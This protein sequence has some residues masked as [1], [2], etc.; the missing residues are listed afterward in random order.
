M[1]VIPAVSVRDD[2]ASDA[3]DMLPVNVVVADANVILAVV[4]NAD[5]VVRVVPTDK[6]DAV[7]TGPVKLAIPDIVIG[8]VAGME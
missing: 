1:A 4:A 5:V 8:L 6:A 2:V 3:I 7:V